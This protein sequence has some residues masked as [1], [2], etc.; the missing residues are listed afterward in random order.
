MY[1][2]RKSWEDSK[3]QIGA[4]SIYENAIN[5]YTSAHEEQ[6]YKIFDVNGSIV[7]PLRHQTAINM[8]SD[9]II[10]TDDLIYWSDC[11]KEN[12]SIHVPNII[13]AFNKYH[14]KL[15]NIEE[16]IEE[17][18][19]I[20]FK[21]NYKVEDD[22][23]ILEIPY[24]EFSIKYWDKP[25]KTSLIKNYFNLGFFAGN[26]KNPDGTTFSLPV[27]NLVCDIEESEIKPYVL[28]FLKKGKIENNKL[29][30]NLAANDGSQFK[31]KVVSTLV[32]DNNGPHIA[33]YE[34][35]SSDP[36]WG[37]TYAISGA[38]V[39]KNGQQ[40]NWSEVAIE[41]WDTSIYRATWHG[42]LGIKN[43]TIYYIAFE[44]KTSNLFT[45]EAYTKLKKY[46]FIDVI[47][48]D[49]GGSFIFDCDGK[50]VA[51]TNENRQINNIGLFL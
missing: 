27:A 29:W 40:V 44:T 47:K 23:H 35:V 25:K 41:G 21:N 19:E 33:R 24:K 45:G 5:A 50:N 15:N 3:S 20:L 51:V 36:K 32:I 38:P 48:L 9:N 30:F 46:N 11:F 17:Q 49:A 4:F 14:N 16:S 43:N 1:R 39:I 13:D 7:Y 34:S 28:N 26:C 31:Q 6:G 42:F 37:V 10:E 8:L 12:G 22:I 18:S 2:I